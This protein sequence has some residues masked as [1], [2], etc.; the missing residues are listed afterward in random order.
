MRERNTDSSLCPTCT[1]RTDSL[2]SPLNT[3]SSTGSA[4]RTSGH[5]G[6]FVAGSFDARKRSR[7]LGLGCEV[8]VDVR[9]GGCRGRC[10]GDAG[11]V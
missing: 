2:S 8:D 5:H 4:A 3:A 9:G 7:S 1:Y 6:L 11:R 10:C